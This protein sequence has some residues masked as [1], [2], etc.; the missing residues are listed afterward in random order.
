MTRFLFQFALA[1]LAIIAI[2]FGVWY[3]VTTNHTDTTV[4]GTLVW[5]NCMKEV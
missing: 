5:N 3:Y 4:H 2:I 1:T